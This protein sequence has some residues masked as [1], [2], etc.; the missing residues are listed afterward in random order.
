MT[1]EINPTIH[2]AGLAALEAAANRA[3]KLAPEA[4]ARLAP[5]HDEVFALHCTAPAVAIY[6]QPRD[7]GIAFMGIYDGPVT[8]SIKGEANDFAELAASSDPAAT[9]INGKLE[10]QGD[11][12]PLIEL[13]KVLA[14]LDLDWEAP[15]VEGL[16]DVAGHQLAAV[17]RATFNWGRQAGTSLERQWSEFIHEEARLTPPRL[18]LEDFYRDVQELSLQVE[19]L[20]SRI[21]RITRKIA[22]AKTNTQGRG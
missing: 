18:E 22:A 4:G 21:A 14:G 1:G 2:T 7:D 13:Q 17:L 10:L 3:L 12:A 19:R 6:L 16:G 15:L 11:S 8:T 5:L 9:L 20:E